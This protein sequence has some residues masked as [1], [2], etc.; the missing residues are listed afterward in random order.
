MSCDKAGLFR[1]HGVREAAH[2]PKL[3]AGT[4]GRV[5]R[6]QGQ[7][8]KEDVLLIGPFGHLWTIRICGGGDGLPYTADCFEWAAG[9][10][11]WSASKYSLNSARG[12][13]VK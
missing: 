12:H 10:Q 8:I 2:V 7:V 13:S 5:L 9:D 6:Q 4:R 3:Q 1:V 11:A